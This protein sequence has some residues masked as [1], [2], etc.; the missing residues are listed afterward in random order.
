MLAL[1]IKGQAVISAVMISK[2]ELQVAF[3]VCVYVKV[4]ANLLIQEMTFESVC[5]PW[6]VSASEQHQLEMEQAELG[7]WHL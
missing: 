4:R 1:V 2:E 3:F 7:S 5:H 6:L